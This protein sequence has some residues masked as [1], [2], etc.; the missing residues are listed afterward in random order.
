MLIIQT[1]LRSLKQIATRIRRTPNLVAFNTKGNEHV[2][3]RAQVAVGKITRRCN[4]N[5]L[6]NYMFKIVT[7][8][9][10]T[11]FRVEDDQPSFHVEKCMPDNHI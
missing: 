2:Q 11:A 9:E 10:L 3:Q 5:L 6:R 8:I 1:L 7:F 4:R